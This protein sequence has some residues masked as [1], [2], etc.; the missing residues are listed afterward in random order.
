MTKEE[1]LRLYQEQKLQ[2]ESAHNRPIVL[3]AGLLGVELTGDCIR[4]FMWQEDGEDS[5]NPVDIIV[6]EMRLLE[7]QI[8]LMALDNDKESRKKYLGLMSRLVEMRSIFHK[9]QAVN[10][11]SIYTYAAR[12]KYIISRTMECVLQDGTIKTFP[13]ETSDIPGW[14]KQY[15]DRESWIK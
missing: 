2:K 4:Y 7:S 13:V 3:E 10:V 11:E 14:R 6:N 5:G 15:V 12:Q 8:D 9:I 1:Q